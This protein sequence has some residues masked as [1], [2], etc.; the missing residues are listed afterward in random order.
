MIEYRVENIEA[1][2]IVRVCNQLGMDGWE[3]VTAIRD[4][5][6]LGENPPFTYIFKRKRY[7]DKGIG[8]L[9]DSDD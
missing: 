1:A 2:D 6:K 7:R 5:G 9:N 4:H 8:T 3:L